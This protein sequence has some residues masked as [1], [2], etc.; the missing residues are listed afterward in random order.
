MFF[1]DEEYH[2]PMMYRGQPTGMYGMAPPPPNPQLEAQR[3]AENERA[4]REGQ[5]R[6]QYMEIGAS[7]GIILFIS[8]NLIVY[9]NEP[10][11]GGFQTWLLG[12]MGIYTC[13]LIMCMNQLM[14]VKKLGRE[15]LW[16][17]LLM[18]FILTVNTSW[19]IYGN[20]IYYRDWAECSQIS[21]TYPIG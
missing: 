4:R 18:V 9:Q 12:S 6:T 16:L 19:Y 11:C 14:Q 5:E 13:D 17:L 7:A 15:N 2:D 21:E 8:L 10:K 3:A 20:I 1:D